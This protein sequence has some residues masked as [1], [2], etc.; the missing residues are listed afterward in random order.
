M[1]IILFW[2]SI[3]FCLLT[4]IEYGQPHSFVEDGPL[5]CIEI[6]CCYILNIWSIFHY[7]YGS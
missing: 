7:V 1:L 3:H 5:L 4:S 6:E 2:C